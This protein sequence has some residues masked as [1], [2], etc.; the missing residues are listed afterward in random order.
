MSFAIIHSLTGFVEGAGPE[1]QPELALVGIRL[2][3]AL[4]PMIA[5]LMGAFIFWKWY[6]L[7]PEKVDENQL[8]IK[9]L[10]L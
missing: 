5:I 6:D 1:A 9:E 10:K 2:H 7:R 3:L 4:V 8:K